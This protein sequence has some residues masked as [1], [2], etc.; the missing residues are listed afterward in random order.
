MIGQKTAGKLLKAAYAGLLT[1]L[2]GLSTLLVGS[3]TFAAVTDGQWVTLSAW[4]LAA[5]GS[6]YGL[7][8]WA[9]PR[10]NGASSSGGP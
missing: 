1:F 2:S 7:A 9:G 3:T 6:V 5:I 10:I 8:G 4:T